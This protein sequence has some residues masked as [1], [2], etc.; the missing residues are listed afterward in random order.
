MV[1]LIKNWKIV[2]RTHCPRESSWILVCKEES[3][4]GLPYWRVVVFMHDG[5]AEVRNM[6]P[7]DL[8]PI[9][10]KQVFDTDHIRKQSEQ[11][12]WIEAN[13][14]IEQTH[15][16]ESDVI[17]NRNK[18]CIIV[19]GVTISRKDLATYLAQLS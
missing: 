1:T 7:R 19:A 9:Q 17:V 11:I 13:R 2:C 4:K 5:K 3:E 12:A 10:L 15:K 14:A 8:E 16:A 6:D 18:G